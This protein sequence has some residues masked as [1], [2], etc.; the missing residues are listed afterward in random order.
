MENDDHEADRHRPF[1]D[2]WE[3]LLRPSMAGR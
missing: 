3:S 1:D 2:A